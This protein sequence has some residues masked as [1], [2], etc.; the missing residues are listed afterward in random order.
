M[1]DAGVVTIMHADVE[2]STALTTRLGDEVGRGVLLETK[3]IVREQA[4]A[5][6]GREID[7]V[8]DALMLTFTSTRQAIAAAIAIQNTL[9]ERER[10]RPDETLRV[11][12]GLNVGE[13][14]ERDRTPFGA[15]VNAGARV[16]SKAAGGQIF[17]SEMVRQL[18]GT[19]PGISYRDRGR[20]AFKGFDERWRLF[21]VV[22]QQPQPKTQDSAV[23]TARRPARRLGRRRVLLLVAL[24]GALAVSAAAGIAV[25]LSRGGA[26]TRVVETPPQSLVGL[27]PQTGSTDVVVNVASDPVALAHGRGALWLASADS[28]TL[29]RVDSETGAAKRVPVPLVPSSVAVGNDAIWVGG[30]GA[31]GLA[32]VDP[33]FLRPRPAK[34]AG[35]G[36]PTSVRALATGDGSVWAGTDDSIVRIEERTGRVL[37]RYPAEGG[38]TALA[39]GGGALFAG[40]PSGRILRVDPV[41]GVSARGV[42]PDSVSGLAVRGRQ[43]WVIGRYSTTVW[44]LDAGSLLSIGSTAIDEEAGGQV[45]NGTGIALDGASTWVST[46]LGV[47]RLDALNDDPNIRAVG[48]SFDFVSRPRAI[49]AAADRIWVAVAERDTATAKTEGTLRFNRP[50]DGDF[51]LDPALAYTPVGNQRSFATCA[52]LVSYP[53]L[54][55]AAGLEIVPELARGLPKVSAS[56]RVYTFHVRDDFRFSP[57]SNAT[58]TAA[59]VKATI[60]RALSPTWPDGPPPGAAFLRDVEGASDYL[61]GDAQEIRGLTVADDVLTV[62]LTRPVPDLL[63]RLALPFFCVLP[64][65]APIVAGGLTSPIPTAGPYYLASGRVGEGPHTIVLRRNP[66]YRGD[67]PRVPERIVYS[68]G[69]DGVETAGALD[70][71]TADYSDG[72]MVE[73][74]YARLL[75]AAGPGTPAARAGRQR[76]FRGPTSDQFY[77]VL[78]TSR[79]LF[80]QPRLRRAVAHALNRPA[81]LRALEGAQGG[82]P[83]DQ[84][85]VRG[86]PGFRDA[87]IHRL[88]GPDLERARAEASGAGGR[89]V[90]WLPS[91]ELVYD[92]PQDLVTSLRAS[93]R[94]IGLELVVEKIDDFGPRVSAPHAAWDLSLLEFEPELPDPANTINQLYEAGYPAAS[95]I[96]TAVTHRLT[97][98]ALNRELRAAARLSGR[99]RLDAYA[100]LDERLAR[101]VA[102]LIPIGSYDQLDSFSERIGCQT[103]H[104]VYGMI[105]GALCFRS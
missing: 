85:L 74:T 68:I 5:H 55:G 12:I 46:D 30:S 79:P 105:L 38:V 49:A 43:L 4:E 101:D 57:P 8:G 97:D 99:A 80:R 2:G 78:N 92:E 102:A 35:D 53:D 98:A 25:T 36:L 7:S 82:T 1:G 60:E 91:F 15:A 72:Q 11:R 47:R 77:L 88:G 29:T 39:F 61:A 27:D 103:F 20:H 86:H 93:M 31:P 40:L 19:V 58:V 34:G 64:S 73:A 70:A 100:R 3:R 14:L 17:V 90:L 16:M 44:H 26:D 104:P 13:V 83:S 59:D 81:L 94:A 32:A 9:A 67:R 18:A 69:P 84:Y 37:R 66:N 45:A 65:G 50:D 95:G 76:I 24:G 51:T 22:W 56:G 96:T 48:A 21:E 89:V 33:V 42:V 63:H 52:K 6:E 87:R 23:S 71:G 62:R 10:E 54:A 41:S 28:R 75:A